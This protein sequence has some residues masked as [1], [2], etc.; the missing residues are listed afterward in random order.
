MIRTKYV[1]MSENIV[2]NRV[3][4]DSEIISV[5]EL[6]PL[7]SPECLRPCIA[8]LCDVGRPTRMLETSVI[9]MR[10]YLA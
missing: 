9:P 3:K 8:L 1:C 2:L 7:G 10:H 4:E 5:C 6:G